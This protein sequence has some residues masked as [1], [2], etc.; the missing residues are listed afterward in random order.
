M[1][2]SFWCSFTVNLIQSRLK[3][4]GTGHCL[5][6]EDVVSWNR[7]KLLVIAVAWERNRT[8]TTLLSGYN[9]SPPSCATFCRGCLCIA[10]T[11]AR[12]RIR[13]FL[14]N[15]PWTRVFAAVIVTSGHVGVRFHR[16]PV[17]TREF[18]RRLSP[19]SVPL[20]NLDRPSSHPE[21]FRRIEDKDPWTS[22]PESFRPLKSRPSSESTPKSLVRYR[23]KC[24]RHFL[25]YPR[26][27]GP[28]GRHETLRPKNTR[29]NEKD[30]VQNFKLNS[31]LNSAL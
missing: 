8:V 5:E 14:T 30:H 9:S 19:F 10:T 23:S 31:F 11:T 15:G 1:N 12:Q 20:E 4:T 18:L 26:Q 28:G 7:S 6:P 22:D 25:T 21:S 16:L 13:T 27:E 24:S 3:N 2:C 29:L 17:S